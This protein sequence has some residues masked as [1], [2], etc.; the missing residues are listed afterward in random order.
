MPQSRSQFKIIGKIR[1]MADEKI[2]I[3]TNKYLKPQIYIP[4]PKC[5]YFFYLFQFLS[6]LVS[7]STLW[8]IVIYSPTNPRFLQQICWTQVKAI[9][10]RAKTHSKFCRFENENSIFQQQ[11]ILINLRFTFFPIYFWRRRKTWTIW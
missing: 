4:F 9:N 6:N 2:K 7:F 11:Q 3:S 5:G 1:N 8:N 10:T